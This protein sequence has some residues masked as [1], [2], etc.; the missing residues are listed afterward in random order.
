[1]RTNQNLDAEKLIKV[2]RYGTY[3]I[4]SDWSKLTKNFFDWL[5]T[6]GMYP[7]GVFH[8]CVAGWL[9]VAGC[10]GMVACVVCY[11]FFLCPLDLCLTLTRHAR[12]YH[13]LVECVCDFLSFFLV[14]GRERWSYEVFFFV[15]FVLFF[16][17]CFFFYILCW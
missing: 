2:P 15:F 8:F 14:R 16:D 3:Y 9:L 7:L 13:C 11:T 10:L 6:C 5:M 4:E 12:T 1:M 17:F